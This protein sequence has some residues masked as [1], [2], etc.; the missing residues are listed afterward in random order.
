MTVLH[1]VN[2]SP[3]ECRTLE[4]CF[5]HAL[6]GS[7]VLFIED[8]V[9]AALAES[10]VSELVSV[11][12]ERLKVYALESDLDARGIVPAR[13]HSAVSRSFQQPTSTP[14]SIGSARGVDRP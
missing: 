10:G 8:G 11:H 1:T 3:F 9:Y 13:R 12:A 5:A 7:V 6:D 4:S 14:G 2:K